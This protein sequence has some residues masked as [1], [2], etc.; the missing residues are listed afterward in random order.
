M[1]KLLAHIATP[2]SAD[3]V[4]NATAA[5]ITRIREVVGSDQAF[6]RVAGDELRKARTRGN[7]LTSIFAIAARWG[8]T[9]MDI[10][11]RPHEAVS[12]SLF[13]LSVD[14]PAPPNKHPF[15]EAGYQHCERTLR[16]LLRLPSATSLPNLRDICRESVV[17]CSNF[18]RKNPDLCRRY[19]TAKQR[20]AEQI[21]TDRI[22]AANNYVARLLDDSHRSGR[23]LHR[24]NAVVEM[25]R[26][27]H[28]PK[29]VARTALSAAL[30][31]MSKDRDKYLSGN[32]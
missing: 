5:F 28:V 13:Q 11:L 23:R 10:L 18:Q 20:Y 21:R 7:R 14:P 27:M 9:P 30:A 31:R 24:K 32:Q 3:I 29:A 2:E 19:T 16:R 25:M 15:N 26:E 1:L 22:A 4:A 12:P 6:K 8:T 17:S